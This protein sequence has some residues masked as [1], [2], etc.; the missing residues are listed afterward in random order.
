[1]CWLNVQKV[2]KYVDFA[3]FEEYNYSVRGICNACTLGGAIPCGVRLKNNIRRK[4]KN[5][6]EENYRNVCKSNSFF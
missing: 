3:L 4:Y 1:M 6:D 2:S 5:E